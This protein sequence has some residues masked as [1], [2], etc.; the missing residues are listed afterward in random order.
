MQVHGAD[1]LSLLEQMK[2]L[3]Y[4]S[5]VL[6]YQLP[7]KYTPALTIPRVLPHTLVVRPQHRSFS[8][9]QKEG[10]FDMHTCIAGREGVHLLHSLEASLVPTEQLPSADQLIPHINGMRAAV[11]QTHQVNVPATAEMREAVAGVECGV[12]SP[13]N[14]GLLDEIKRQI[15]HTDYHMDNILMVIRITINERRLT[16]KPT[17]VGPMFGNVMI[18]PVALTGIMSKLVDVGRHK[19]K[20][21]PTEWTTDTF[22]CV[23]RRTPSANALC[24]L[25]DRTDWKGP[26]RTPCNS[27]PPACRSAGEGRPAGADAG[28]CIGAAG[29]DRIT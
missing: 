15:Q 22:I 3:D 27:T 25:F 17:I 5:D 14:E 7:H 10:V 29:D 6:R 4:K 13:M 21:T 20:Y 26:D 12:M 9:L 11:I 8:Q 18:E 1:R 2:W 23:K 24:F 19:Y 16:T 28:C